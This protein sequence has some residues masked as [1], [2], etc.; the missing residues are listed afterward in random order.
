[1]FHQLVKRVFSAYIVCSTIDPSLSY[2][3]RI[4]FNF[5]LTL[6]NDQTIFFISL[7]IKYFSRLYFILN[8][9]EQCIILI[10]CYYLLV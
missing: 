5:V 4:L 9:Y 2:R 1:M 3:R 10:R 8:S 6:K 7:R